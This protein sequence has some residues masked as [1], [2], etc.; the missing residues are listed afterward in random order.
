[1]SSE[2][3]DHGRYV[4]AM[5]RLG[6]QWVRDQIFS[7]VI[8]AGYDDVNP[9]HIGLIRY[10]TLDGLRP[11]EL[12]EQLQIT[13]QSVNDLLGHLEQRGY[14]VREPDPADGRARVVRLTAKGR[15]L[16]ET[17]KGQA[18]AAELR[19]AEMLGPIRFAQMRQALEE[20]TD[21]V[22]RNGS[23]SQMTSSR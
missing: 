4:G 13:K 23:A 3:V 2:T 6:W 16:E 5:M 14:L 18:Q 10:P 22:T 1:M 9:A 7:G 15:R 11:S 12:A 21:V 20:L 17:V 19:I 8:A